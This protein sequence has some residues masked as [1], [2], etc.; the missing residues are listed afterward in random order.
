[1]GSINTVETI[2]ISWSIFGSPPKINLLLLMFTLYLELRTA[3]LNY[4]C[5]VADEI[6]L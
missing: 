2:K 3:G 1:M 6:G 5:K 4:P